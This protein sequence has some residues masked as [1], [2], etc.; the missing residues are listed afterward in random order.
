M[1]KSFSLL[2]L[3]MLAL[4]GSSCPSRKDP[5]S[6]SPTSIPPA[7]P[8]PFDPTLFAPLSPRA[9]DRRI[10][11]IMYHDIVASKRQK[12]VFFDCTDDEFKD[13]IAYLES[14]GATF[15]SAEQLHRHLVRGDTVPEKSV[16]L[17]FDDNYQGFYNNAYP[18]LKSKKI[19]S[20]KIGRAH[21]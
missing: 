16:L 3:A 15:I 17:T 6:G 5:I 4:G 9:Q 20:V 2:V 18:L 11:V 8:Q 7:T 14:Q 1:K 12:T 10:P 13:Q 19:P 21:V